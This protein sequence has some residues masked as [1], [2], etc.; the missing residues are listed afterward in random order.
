M[1]STRAAR[2]VVVDGGGQV[3]L[4]HK[5]GLG[6]NG[7]MQRM[8]KRKAEEVAGDARG[9]RGKKRAALGEITNVGNYDLKLSCKRDHWYQLLYNGF[10]HKFC[11]FRVLGFPGE[12][13]SRQKGSDK[14]SK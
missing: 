9:S 3:N 14:N 12:D 11:F 7:V 1:P 5:N 6:N 10:C 8:A 13:H 2:A 4:A